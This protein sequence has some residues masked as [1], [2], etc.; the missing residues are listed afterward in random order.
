MS[1]T[2]RG[3]TRPVGRDKRDVTSGTWERKG[4][5]VATERRNARD[6]QRRESWTGRGRAWTRLEM[7]MVLGQARAGLAPSLAVPG[8]DPEQRLADARP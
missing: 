7:G 5:T 6:G 2:G 4:G 1:V 8:L 3:G